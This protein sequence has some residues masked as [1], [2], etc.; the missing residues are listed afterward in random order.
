VPLLQAA[1]SSLQS[2]IA[3]SRIHAAKTSCFISELSN[4]LAAAYEQLSACT[5][6]AHSLRQK[7]PCVRP[8]D[9]MQSCRVNFGACSPN[10]IGGDEIPYPIVWGSD[11]E[12]RCCAEMHGFAGA[13]GRPHS[14]CAVDVD[15]KSCAVSPER[16]IPSKQQD[17]NQLHCQDRNMH[18]TQT[19]DG[20][21]RDARVNHLLISGVYSHG[22]P[23]LPQIVPASANEDSDWLPG[24]GV[25]S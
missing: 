19:V 2:S 5:F 13:G 17:D 4:R 14:I 20:A 16:V 23:C 3:S 25:I 1:A 18:A 24:D 6:A 21:A 11:F 12:I 9:V 10:T 15:L 8:D 22:A 7:S